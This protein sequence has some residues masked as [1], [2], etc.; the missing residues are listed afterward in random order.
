MARKIRRWDTAETLR[1][2]EDIAAYL[3]AVLDD[4]D[5]ALLKVAM[6]NI[7]RAKGVTELARASGLG[8]AK[9][10]KALS[11]SNNPEFAT[12]LKVLHVLGFRYTAA[13]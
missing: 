3:N 5:P 9:L 6:G 12:V 4:G 1:T 2:K 7:I 8:R 10:C 11:S 13:V